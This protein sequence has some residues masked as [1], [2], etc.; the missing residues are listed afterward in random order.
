MILEIQNMNLLVEQ[1][2]LK[3]C[4]R[5]AIGNSRKLTGICTVGRELLESRLL[6]QISMI[7]YREILL[8]PSSGI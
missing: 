7:S 2:E 5:D 4:S 1:K 3:R 6:F 8:V